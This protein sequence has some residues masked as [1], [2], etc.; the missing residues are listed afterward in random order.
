M[1]FTFVQLTEKLK[2]S[3]Y[4]SLSSI[5]KILLI[6]QAKS[7]SNKLYNVY[8]KNHMEPN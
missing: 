3:D 6:K 8:E 7:V 5:L 4:L 1:I 2:K